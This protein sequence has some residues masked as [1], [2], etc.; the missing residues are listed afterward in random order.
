MQRP[1][2]WICASDLVDP[3]AWLE[4]RRRVDAPPKIIGPFPSWKAFWSIEIL[5]YNWK[6]LDLI[7]RG[8]P[9]SEGVRQDPHRQRLRRTDQLLVRPVRTKRALSRAPGLAGLLKD[10]RALR[11]A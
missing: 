6:H 9:L 2:T 8:L 1:V 5:W 11:L 7:A 3:G 4:L 10:P